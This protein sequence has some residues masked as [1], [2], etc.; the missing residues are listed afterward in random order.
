MLDTYIVGRLVQWAE[1]ATRRKDSGLGFPKKVSYADLM[2]RTG[3]SN[4]TPEFS[5]E[6]FDIDRCV[7]A[8]Q[9]EGE[10][11]YAVIILHYTQHHMT[12]E[13]KSKQLGCC[14]KTYYNKIDK[15]H[16]LILGWLNDLS[17]G[18]ALPYIE[19]DLNKVKKIA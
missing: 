15:A 13:Q 2:P 10:I 16:R 4:L 11:Y 19:V 17:V 7:A 1:W 8:L 14:N 18:L 5:D 3:P 6:C 9:T 12:L